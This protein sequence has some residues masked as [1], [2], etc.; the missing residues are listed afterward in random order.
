MSARVVW[1]STSTETRGG[2]ASYVR[3]M[4]ATPLWDSWDVHHIA[5]HRDGSVASRVRAFARGATAFLWMLTAHPP[6]LV[7]LHMASR[8]SFA[9]KSILSWM[10]H[11]RGLPVIIHVH[12]G[13]F[14]DFYQASPRPLRAYI[15]ATLNRA[16]V[17]VA[18][19]PTWARRLGEIAPKSR[20]V[21]V[22]NG[23]RPRAPVAQ[24]G[25]HG[26]VR[27]L[28]L[29][30]IS[31]GKGAFALLEAWGRLAR[32]S[33]GPRAEL[34]LAGDGAVDQARKEVQEKGLADQVQVLGWVPPEEV[35]HLLTTSQVLALPSFHEGQPMAVLEA[36]ARGLCVVASD[37]GGI[38]DLLGDACGVL[39]PVGDVDALVAALDQVVTHESDRLRLGTRA[40]NRVHDR[41]DVDHT[42]RALDALYEE[43]SA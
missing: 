19:G 41:F 35:D 29:G 24:P 33:T 40:W 38:P 5:T 1:L 39:V 2:V 37:V 6:G 28:F 25:P 4:R 20:V 14:Q 27:V 23:V 42:W 3:G 34:V 26:V 17:I 15:R 22:P 10:A 36:M 16:D 11:A 21:V 31:V 32:S 7:H 12:G 8:G 13:G 30:D 18:L 9:R 43:L